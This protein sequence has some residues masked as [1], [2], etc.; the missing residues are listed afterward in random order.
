MV[1]VSR[2]YF[3]L[4]LAFAGTSVTVWLV[5]SVSGLDAGGLVFLVMPLLIAGM[6]EG[7]KF[8]QHHRRRPSVTHC[9]H[10]ALHMALCVAVFAL[11]TAVFVWFADTGAAPALFANQLAMII[12]ILMSVPLLR[13]GYAIG[14]ASVL[15]GQATADF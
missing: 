2:F 9:W 4:L 14:L 7:Q 13:I 10:A 15:K 1:G 11:G 6:L 5:E 12:F 3:N 8:A